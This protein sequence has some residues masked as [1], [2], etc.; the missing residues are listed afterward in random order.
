MALRLKA[1]FLATQLEYM[2]ARAAAVPEETLSLHLAAKS[3]GALAQSLAATNRGVRSQR[4]PDISRKCSIGAIVCDAKVSSRS[5]R[6]RWSGVSRAKVTPGSPLR[7][8]AAEAR[9]R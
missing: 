9:T 3:A 8:P 4:F 7:E 1:E 6:R 5:W 2:I